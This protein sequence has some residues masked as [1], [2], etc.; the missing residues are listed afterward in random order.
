[1]TN[2][3]SVDTRKWKIQDHNSG[4]QPFRREKSS[5]RNW[6]PTPFFLFPVRDLFRANS[7]ARQ[8][9]HT[10]FR[11]SGLPS[12]S[13]LVNFFENTRDRGHHNL[14]LS[15]RAF[16]KSFQSNRPTLSASSIAGE[17][18][19]LHPFTMLLFIITAPCP[20]LPHSPQTTPLGSPS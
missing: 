15:P 18:K 8:P 20:T 12:G 11:T 2:L 9:F 3:T 16:Q 13:R 7:S 17:L 6:A 4:Q 19:I 10:T 5:L 1:M 14:T